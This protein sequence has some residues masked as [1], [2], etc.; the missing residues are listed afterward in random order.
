MRVQITKLICSIKTVAHIT[1]PTDDD[2]LNEGWSIIEPTN[3]SLLASTKD[4]SN[5]VLPSDVPRPPLNTNHNQYVFYHKFPHWL[6]ELKIC[7]GKRKHVVSDDDSYTTE[8]ETRK[9][10]KKAPTSKKRTKTSVVIRKDIL[11]QDCWAKKIEPHQVVCVGCAKTIK[12]DK[13]TDYDTRPWE[14]HKAVCAQVSGVEKVRSMKPNVDA[15]IEVSFVLLFNTLCLQITQATKDG[16]TDILQLFYWPIKSCVTKQSANTIP[17]LCGTTQCWIYHTSNRDSELPHSCNQHTWVTHMV[18]WKNP[19]IA[20]IFQPAAIANLSPATKQLPTPS[21]PTR[22]ICQHLNS[23]K[24]EEYITHMHTRSLGG[25]SFQQRARI[26]RQLF[27][28]KP[29]PTPRTDT[30]NN[31][32]KNWSEDEEEEV[33]GTD[34]TK[35]KCE[36]PEDGNKHVKSTMWTIAELKRHDENMRGWARWEVD[37]GVKIVRSTKCERT[38]TNVDGVCEECQIVSKDGSFKADVRKVP[39]RMHFYFLLWC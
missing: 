36:V 8:I 1:I 20:R 28:Y 32:A 11:E 13:K 18:L 33:T 15:V 27:P 16:I 37:I 35:I 17:E 34:G 3:T 26:I 2:D 6:S 39:F 31:E 7:S 25:I 21:P 14:K 30:K 29:F 24:Y 22:V 9:L 5:A 23:D 4:T 10:K 12:L 19:S 38:T